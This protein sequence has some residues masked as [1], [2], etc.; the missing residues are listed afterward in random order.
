MVDDKPLIDYKIADLD[1]HVM[2]KILKTLKRTKHNV[3]ATTIVHIYS[4]LK[5]AI[6]YIYN[7]NR[8]HFDI[9]PSESKKAKI[10]RPKKQVWCPNKELAREVLEA[11]DK[12][13]NPDNAL[14]TH[15]CSLGLRSSEVSPLKASDFFFNSPKPFVKITRVQTRYGIK[16][17][18]LKNGE[19]ERF[20]YIGARSVE[21]IKSYII[22]LNGGDWLFP[23]KKKKNKPRTHNGLVK[24]GIKKALQIIGKD[25]DWK[26]CVHA[27]RHYYASII[28]EVAMKEKKSFKWI[29]KQLGH[30]DLATTMN[31][32]GHLIEAD[33]DDIG[34]VI[35]QSLYY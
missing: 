33:D 10:S 20:V 8:K 2:D 34:D 16:Y 17:N 9:N 15:L 18:E 11:V 24:G 12:Y 21:R 6:T 1:D 26:G 13:C 3:S 29:P 35:E 31:I 25:S 7:E 30:K 14:F 5:S 32:Y 27:L 28:I 23:S 4:V 19:Q 22:R